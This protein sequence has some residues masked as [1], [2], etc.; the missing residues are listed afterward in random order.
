[1]AE[2][3]QTTAATLTAAPITDLRID[4]SAVDMLAA[5]GSK[6]TGVE[7][8]IVD[9][10]TGI[11]GLPDQF[12]VGVVH[13]DE[14]RLVSVK[15]FADEW[16]THPPFRIGQAR[17][18]T[19]ESFIALVNRQKEADSAIFCDSD[20][21]KPAMTAVI[22]YHASDDDRDATEIGAGKHRVHYAFPLSEEWKGW[23]KGDGVP[24]SQQDFAEMIEDRIGDLVAPEDAWAARAERDFQTRIANPAQMLTLSR[25]LEVNV[26]A[27]V[28]ESKVLQSGEGSLVFEETHKDSS[29]AAIKV[30]GLFMLRIA[31]FFM[32]DPVEIP[33]RLRYRVRAGAIIWI[34]Q[35]YRP[36]QSITEA[37][38][39]AMQ[40]V[41]AKTELPVFEGAPE[42]LADGKPVT[43]FTGA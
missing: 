22:D 14:P 42:M 24:M 35:I 3:T 28:K 10:D 18:L 21:R 29:G 31:P 11:P 39:A 8:T 25:G 37:V 16:R 32:G 43:G 26:E 9:Y 15:A 27:R 1:M 40:D 23:I 4:G 6:A 12:P 13:G 30:P 38:R 34:Y 17:A 20:W 19:L 5:L 41:R 2:T 7:I 33:V 36:D